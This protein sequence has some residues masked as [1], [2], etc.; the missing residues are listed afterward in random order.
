MRGYAAIVGVFW[1]KRRFLPD[2]TNSVQILLI[3]LIEALLA[4]VPE[5]DTDSIP[6]AAEVP[7]GLCLSGG[8]FR[9]ALYG[10]G[11]LRYLAESDL[12][13]RVA[14]VCGV[15][16]GSVV[17]A[18]FASALK[19]AGDKALTANG[20]QAHAFDPFVAAVTTRDLRQEAV[21]RWLRQR[22]RP[23]ALP[24][25]LVLA[26]VLAEALFPA[27]DRL[28]D[29][30]ERPQLI[31]TGTELTAG[32]AFRFSRDFI[33]S[34]DFGYAPTPLGMRVAAAVAASA[35]APPAI[36]ALQL[37]THGMGL[38]QAPPLL[39]IT[40]GGVYDNLGIEWFQ[41][42]TPE[43]RPAPAVPVEDLIVV[44]ASGPLG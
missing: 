40:D 43:R 15:S 7:I 21:W 17:T 10:L 14:V 24:R 23:R 26:E 19:V 25:N 33:G 9:A 42:W 28:A 12:L 37:R 2:R 39:A 22:L 38:K 34:W 31:F 3:S 1:Q 8:G 16:G 41:G 6:R 30:P 32:R 4:I 20:F 5:R 11:V 36:P 35:A 27:A 29:L 44:N 13:R 18:A